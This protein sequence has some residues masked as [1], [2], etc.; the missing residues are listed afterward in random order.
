MLNSIER[1]R[2]IV[3]ESFLDRGTARRGGYRGVI[4]EG[5]Q[6][7]YERKN[8]LLHIF[9][10]EAKAPSEAAGG[11]TGL[12]RKSRELGGDGSRRRHVR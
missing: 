1:F 6:V 2:T 9:R 10:L 3:N 4:L 8:M 5:R 11:K 7:D 12:G